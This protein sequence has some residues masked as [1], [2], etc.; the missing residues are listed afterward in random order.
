MK[1]ASPNPSKVTGLDI[2]VADALEARRADPAA[3]RDSAT[4]VVR[5]AAT[6]LSRARGD[7][8]GGGRGDSNQVRSRTKHQLHEDITV[9]DTKTTAVQPR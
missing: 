1:P 6:S 4:P 7:G 5:I 9:T 2:T 8:V 3:K